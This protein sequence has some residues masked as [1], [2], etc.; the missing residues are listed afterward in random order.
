[1]VT[2][3]SIR[4][5]GG[6]L[7]P[8]VLDKLVSGDLPGQKPADFGVEGKRNLTDEMATAFAD[9]RALW[10]VF[11][12]RLARLDDGDIA[13]TVTR[14]AWVVPFLGLLGYEVRYNPRAFEVD[15][16]SFAVSHRAG[17]PEDAPP[18]HIVGARQELG[19]VAASGK[20]RLAPHSLVQEYL[21]R[22]EHVWGIV[23]NGQTVRLLHDSTLIRRQAYVEFDLAAMIEEQRFQ[24][25][26]AFYRLLH[27]SRLPR[28]MA[29]AGDCLLE[30]YHT[31]SIEQGGRVREHLREGVERAIDQL[32]NGFL[33]NAA[34][35]DLRRRVL[36]PADKPD[37]ISSE[38]FY[39]QLLR[40]VY[41]FLFLL[42]SEDRD[43]IS[44]SELYRDHYSIA[45]LRRLLDQPAAWTDHD[46]LWQSLRVLWYLLRSDV[47]QMQL[48]GKPLASTL[49]LPVL[50]GELFEGH[51]L[52]DC[53]IRNEDLLAALWN[54]AYYTET[55]DRRRVGAT[56]RVNYAALD[57]EELGS[58][59]ESLLEFH[60]AIEPDPSDAQRRPRFQLVFGSDRKTTGSYYT[61]PE[62]VGELI[63]SALEPVIED[64]LAAVAKANPKANDK[65]LISAR[66]KALLSIRTC[67]PA[68]G[69]GHFLLAAARRLGKELAKVRTGED[70]P[71]PER[72]R[73]AIRDVVSHCIYGVDRNPLAVDL[74]RVALWLESHAEGKPLTFLDHRVR[75]GDSLIGVSDLEVL[76][77][78]IPD[79]AF[80]PLEGDDKTVARQF[81]RQNRDERE[82][83]GGLFAWSKVASLASLTK[84]SSEVDAIADDSPEAIRRKRR[85]FE[86]A[87]Q[88][89]EYR[90]QKEACDLWTA[91]FF[92]SF[93]SGQPAITTGAL[94]EHLGGRSVDARLS[95]IARTSSYQ[96]RF[97]HLPL[98][99]PEVVEAGGFDVILSNP[100]WERVKLS[101]QEFFD[102]R[103]AR[104]AT[105]P[106]KAAR[107]KLIK[108]L[109]D[110]NPALF[111]EFQSAVRAAAGASAF[112][113]HS[114]RFPL[115][116]RGDINTYAV[117][118]ELAAGTTHPTGRAGLLV[119]TGIATDDTTKHLFG[120]FVRGRRLVELIGFEN[121]SFIFPAVHHAF[122]FCALAISGIERPVAKS[123]IAFFV[124]RFSELNE[125]NRF[126]S[127]EASDFTLLNPNTSNCPV[128]R[129]RL[130]A[131]LSKAIYRRMPVL[132]R[133]ASDEAPE[134]NPWRLTFSRLFDLSNDS[135]HFRSAMELERDGYRLEGNEYKS[136]F[137]RYLPLYEAKMVHQFDHR[138]GTYEGATQSQ[139]NVGT[140]PRPTPD[141]KADMGFTVMPRFWVRE[142]IVDSM[143]PK[144]PA[145]LAQALDIEHRPSIQFI[146][147]NWAAAACR[148]NGNGR[149]AERLARMAI[150]FDVDPS[151]RSD[152]GVL[153]SEGS[154]EDFARTF[155]LDDNDIAAVQSVTAKPETLAQEL[156]RR[157]SP[158]WFAGWR[159]ITSAV[160]ERTLIVSAM[161]RVAIG[162]KTPLLLSTHDSRT[163]AV[164]MAVLN[165]FVCDY[166]ARQ[167]VGG[168]SFNYFIIKQVAVP[169]PA[170]FAMPTAWCKGVALRDWLLPRVIELTCTANDLHALGEDVGWD[171]G[172]AT[173]SE[174]RRFELRCE[175]D[176]AMFHVYL[177]VTPSGEW[178]RV[179][180][181]EQSHLDELRRC[182]AS[183]R[184]AAAFILEQFPLVRERDVET[185]GTYRTRDSVLK[186]YDEMHLAMRA[187]GEFASSLRPPPAKGWVP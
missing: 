103:D 19:R 81:A 75:C 123:R 122:K 96:Q 171:N 158:K 50:N 131:E 134:F 43:L 71:A 115:G 8:D 33:R 13:T 137:D 38:D 11:Q 1:M 65:S 36:L 69:S 16:M 47:P 58:V 66:E 64:R 117:F 70:E 160:T 5:E 130:D 164:L 34:N 63:R 54:L 126:F 46:D 155:P 136:A 179:D 40:L 180:L 107:S 93:R 114:G 26:A 163:H 153:S 176:A 56:R 162:N 120:S 133:E 109:P 118:A 159:D 48:S 178:V 59:Y 55:L 90:Q 151:L 182:F 28:G 138:Y 154:A 167:K 144:Y 68:C 139:L 86:A 17:E 100:P 92:Q 91:A 146:L 170:S 127:L 74:C 83:Q 12:N 183:P 61:P 42:V 2:Y 29:D 106:T 113:R 125:G 45:R 187:G 44:D 184:D 143:V 22:T 152:C 79:K 95:A 76:K 9:A 60:P 116:G 62:L 67:D 108:L 57:V 20:P 185:H 128:F 97:F 173:W 98:E 121:E 14:D 129:S 73:E 124:R 105:A 21:N 102:V 82:G 101:E 174:E 41:R 110:E 30:Q 77:E 148:I 32:A 142:E 149:D 6:L 186:F 52:D 135:H 172:P 175:L 84:H 39:R 94:R 111:R 132:W 27:R 177:P 53:T 150:A 51:T 168:T 104:I 3:P 147:C 31:Q 112:L 23:T 85:L 10:G 24:D 145:I 169:S 181:E 25:F 18:I 4:I 35:E 88:S 80:D 99:F 141:Q 119:P 15:G 140:L 49:G 72:V 161:P 7:G 37:R 165:S 78:G 166:C 156:V 89:L 87:H 157:F